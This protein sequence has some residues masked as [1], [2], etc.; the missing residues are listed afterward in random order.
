MLFCSKDAQYYI[1]FSHINS[2]GFHCTLFILRLS[3]MHCN[4]CTRLFRSTML[5]V[6]RRSLV[7]YLLISFCTPKFNPLNGY[8]KYA[9]N[10]NEKVMSSSKTPLL[11][12]LFSFSIESWNHCAVPADRKS[13]IK[14]I[15]ISPTDIKTNTKRHMLTHEVHRG[16]MQCSCV[17]TMCTQ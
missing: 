6:K 7:C 15:Y 3:T 4:S 9:V 2:Q 1:R 5:P 13:T 8:N 14:N 17:Y 16:T 12:G 10:D 11:N